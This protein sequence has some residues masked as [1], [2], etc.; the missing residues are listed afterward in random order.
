MSE[1]LREDLLQL[2]SL[3]EMELEP[4]P[5]DG[6]E[7]VDNLAFV[8]IFDTALCRSSSGL[9]NDDIQA[10]LLSIARHLQNEV[11]EEEESSDT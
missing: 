10:C 9:L 6:E 2:F 3:L 8:T 5:E 11:E 7:L 4:V 1:E